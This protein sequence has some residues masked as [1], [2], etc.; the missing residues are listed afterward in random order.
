MLNVQLQRLNRSILEHLRSG[1]NLL[2]TEELS[3]SRKKLA[4][5]RPGDWLDLGESPLEFYVRRGEK[6]LY[7][8]RI[9][10]KEGSETLLIEGMPPEPLPE[11]PGKKRTILEGRVAV[12]PDTLREGETMEFPWDLSE[13]ILLFEGDRAVVEARLVAYDG[14]YA[15]E[16][17]ERIDEA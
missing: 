13:H 12:L 10:T 3:I 8:A 2:V 16:I 6:R 11:R 1:Q 4:K 5:M 7:R 15:L 14:G 9:G 17:T